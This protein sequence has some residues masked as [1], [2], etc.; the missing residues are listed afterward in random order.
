VRGYGHPAFRAPYMLILANRPRD[1][2]S[3]DPI[4]PHTFEHQEEHVHHVFPRAWCV[5]NGVDEAPRESIVNKTPLSGQTN[6]L[7]GGRAPSEY[8]RLI[9]QRAGLTSEE[10]DLIIAT[11]EIDPAAL[12]ADDFDGFYS[13][14]AARLEIQIQA[15][16]TGSTGG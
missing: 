12:R 14:R 11:H 15:V 2:A 6:R 16:M 13:S 9:E 8:L 5:A 7:V 3:G 4:T 10:L 1:F